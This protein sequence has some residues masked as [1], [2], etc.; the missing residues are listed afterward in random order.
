MSMLL[1]GT[2][3]MSV[4]LLYILGP[5][6]SQGRREETFWSDYCKV[7]ALPSLSTFS[8]PLAPEG[9]SFLLSPVGIPLSHYQTASPL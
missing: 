7:E 1:E 3:K 8:P 6:Y 4:D 9:M 5:I 2:W